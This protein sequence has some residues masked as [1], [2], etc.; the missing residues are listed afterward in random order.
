VCP[1]DFTEAVQNFANFTNGKR[2]EENSKKFR[3]NIMGETKSSLNI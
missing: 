1:F 2:E 3:I